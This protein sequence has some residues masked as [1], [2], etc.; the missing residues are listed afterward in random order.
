MLVY[1]WG[2]YHPVKLLNTKATNYF[3]HFSGKWISPCFKIDE[4]VP[5]VRERDGGTNLFIKQQIYRIKVYKYNNNY[6][7]KLNL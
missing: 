5:K 7:P 4:K 3:A 1:M 2:K 6:F